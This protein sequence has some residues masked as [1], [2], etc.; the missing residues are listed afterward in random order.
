MKLYF[1]RSNGEYIKISDFATYKNVEYEI[2]KYCLSKGYAITYTRSWEDGRGTIFDVGSHT[3][4]F[5]L[6]SK[7]LIGGNKL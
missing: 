6:T 7:N 4:F 5:V 3:E 1:Q 2:S